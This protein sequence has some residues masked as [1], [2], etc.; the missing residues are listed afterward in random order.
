MTKRFTSVLSPSAFRALVQA[1][2]PESR[3]IPVDAT[4]YMPNSPSNGYTEFQNARLPGS[5][6][7]DIEKV[8]DAE[9][10]YPHMLPSAE[11]F[12]RAISELGIRRTDKL[13][14]YD[15]TG[16]FS[17]PRAAWTFGLFG[18]PEIYILNHWPFYGKSGFPVDTNAVQNP[19]ALAPSLYEASN[20]S[21][22]V[23]S[24]EELLELVKSGKLAEYQLIDA[25][26]A[27]RFTAKAP[28]PRPELPS[29]HVPGAKS[30]PFQKVWSADGRFL[31]KPEMVAVLDQAGIVANQKTIVMCGSGVTACVLKTAL[32]IAGYGKDS[33][34][35]EIVVYDGSWSE[36]AAR[37]PKEYI[38]KGSA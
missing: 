5:V 16:V 7:F 19:S 4:W 17:S 33:S 22:G 11:A 6:F 14:F 13:V 1:S 20:F 25:R 26:S 31:E 21:K 37:A 3:V 18:H 27:D 36:W 23:I 2:T 15:K 10:P 24:Y 35:D 12:S 32:D 29:G 28:E 30:L 9:S 34:G 38:A 8:K